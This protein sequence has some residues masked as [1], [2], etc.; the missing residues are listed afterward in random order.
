MI[1]GVNYLHLANLI[2]MDLKPENILF[3]NKES[4]SIKLIDFHLTQST[5]GE[6]EVA[7][8]KRPLPS[9][10]PG[11]PFGTPYYVA[12]EVIKLD[13]NGNSTY[14]EK[15]DMWSIGC[16]LYTMLTGFPPFQGQN[17][18]ETIAKVNLGI[19]SK[20]TL[21]DSGISEEC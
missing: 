6:G 18:A 7:I 16:I 5:L 4:S 9:A 21:N 13:K 14:T 15:C 2:H 1:G 19:Y 8:L 12:P 17:D 11:K 20:E 3:S 10:A